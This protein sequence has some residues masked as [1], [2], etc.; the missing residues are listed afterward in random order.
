MTGFQMGNDLYKKLDYYIPNPKCELNYNKDYELLIATVLSAQCTDKRVNMVTSE[1]FKNRNLNDI[2]SM[3][4][5]NI[6][7]IIHCLGSYERKAV[8]VKVIASRLVNDFNSSVPN[9]RGYLLSL[10]GVGT[11]TCNVVLKNLFNEP[12]I[13]VDTHVMRVCQ[14][15]KIARL[16]DSP[17]VIERKLQKL[18]PVDKWNRVSEQILLFGRYFCTSRNPKCENCLFKEN[19]QYKKK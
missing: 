17:Q 19:C 12:S 13:P 3:S 14:R 16:S 4:V 11:K 9:N 2:A 8:Y 7:M 18:I 1:L 5:S 15:W 6:K 10:P